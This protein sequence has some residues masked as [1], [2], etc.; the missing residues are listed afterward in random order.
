LQLFLCEL[1]A[2]LVRCPIGPTPFRPLDFPSGCSLIRL[3]L[4]LCTLPCIPLAESTNRFDSQIF[5][6][7]YLGKELEDNFGAAALTEFG[8]LSL[9]MFKPRAYRE[10]WRGM[11]GPIAGM[12]KSA[13][14]VLE[15]SRQPPAYFRF[16]TDHRTKWQTMTLH[17]APQ[18]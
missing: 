10:A 5:V 11:E 13:K 7:E 14:I 16:F 8:R 15:E 1:V 17:K 9:L 18:L 12:E 2:R 4:L 6:Y 3:I